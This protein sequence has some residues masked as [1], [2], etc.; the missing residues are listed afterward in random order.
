[1][2]YSKVFDTKVA[3]LIIVI[4]AAFTATI[5]TLFCI[6]YDKEIKYCAQITL[7]TAIQ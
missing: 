6:Q 4:Q 5:I 3:T 7:F 1:M 2:V